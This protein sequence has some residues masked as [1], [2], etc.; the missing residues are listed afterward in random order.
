MILVHP[1]A[2]G[3]SQ[4]VIN[5]ESGHAFVNPGASIPIESEYRLSISENEHDQILEITI[6]DNGWLF[7]H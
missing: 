6:A 1:Y 5:L 2:R 7:S 4:L 3:D